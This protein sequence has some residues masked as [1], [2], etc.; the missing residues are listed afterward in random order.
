[1]RINDA[2]QRKT[3]NDVNKNFERRNRNSL[4][5]PILD[6]MVLCAGKLLV[7]M[8]LAC[9]VVSAAVLTA[10][11]VTYGRNYVRGF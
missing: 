5:T 9:L 2:A 6:K 3:L 7:F 1:M 11:F 4:Q 10:M 8:I